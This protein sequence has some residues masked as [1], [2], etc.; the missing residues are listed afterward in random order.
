MKKL[1][2]NKYVHIPASLKF[3]GVAGSL[4]ALFTIIFFVVVILQT[5]IFIKEWAMK[6]LPG[7][8]PF[9]CAALVV[10]FLIFFCNVSLV[11]PSLC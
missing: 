5:T 11:I 10:I 2:A 7:I 6:D 4:W 8:L 3:V 1:I 9:S